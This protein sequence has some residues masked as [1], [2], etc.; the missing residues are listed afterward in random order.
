MTPNKPHHLE[1]KP[2]HVSEIVAGQCDP[3]LIAD[4]NEMLKGP[5]RKSGVMFMWRFDVTEVDEAQR[6]VIQGAYRLAG[7]YVH[8][9]NG[10]YLDDQDTP[11]DMLVFGL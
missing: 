7:W 4:I 5:R 9:I 10:I 3:K 11:A 8:E 2:V 1:Y 6:A